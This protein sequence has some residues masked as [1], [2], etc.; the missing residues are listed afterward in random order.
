MNDEVEAPRRILRRRSKPAPFLFDL[1]EARRMLGGISKTTIYQ[2]IKK[3][4]L[5]TV[6][7]GARSFVTDVELRRYVD[8]LTPPSIQL[9]DRELQA[10]RR[11]PVRR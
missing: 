9:T 1:T 6:K 3:G 8:G 10:V 5:N 4:E 2:L 7:I 11:R